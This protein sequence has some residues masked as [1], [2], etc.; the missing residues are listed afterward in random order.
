LQ[1]GFPEI[2]VAVNAA[3]DLELWKG[4]AQYE[5]PAAWG[6]TGLP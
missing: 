3:Q 4:F 1:A 2:A 5:R 6:T